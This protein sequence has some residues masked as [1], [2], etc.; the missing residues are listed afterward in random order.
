MHLCKL[1]IDKGILAKSGGTLSAV[2]KVRVEWREP[3]F[4]TLSALN[5]MRRDLFAALLEARLRARGFCEPL[6]LIDDQNQRLRLEFRRS[7]CEMDL[8]LAD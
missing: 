4:L 5:R 7:E 1:I 2:Q 8:Y 6:H 3:W